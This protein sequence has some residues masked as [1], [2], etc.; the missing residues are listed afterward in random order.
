MQGLHLRSRD[1]STRTNGFVNIPERFDRSPVGASC[2]SVAVSPA[3]AQR[4]AHENVMEV[5]SGNPLGPGSF[6]FGRQRFDQNIQFACL[7]AKQEGD[8]SDALLVLAIQ[9]E[10]PKDKAFMGQGPLIGNQKIVEKSINQLLFRNEMRLQCPKQR[11]PGL[12]SL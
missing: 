3:E 9:K 8:T 11:L 6:H 10:G 1:W 12:R 7:D 5:P 2:N 4:R